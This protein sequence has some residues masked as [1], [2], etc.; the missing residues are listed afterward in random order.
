MPPVKKWGIRPTLLT[1][2]LRPGPKW[3]RLLVQFSGLAMQERLYL[4]EGD[5]V[6]MIVEADL[7][8][9]EDS[10]A[11]K[12][13]EADPEALREPDRG[14]NLKFPYTDFEIMKIGGNVAAVSNHN[15][16]EFAVLDID[17][18]PF[19]SSFVENTKHSSRV[20][21]NPHLFFKNGNRNYRH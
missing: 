17:P 19:R 12:N 14:S 5:L 1:K 15:H 4:L 9:I 13:V 21:I 6:D 20:N 8:L 3:P 7:E 18:H 16:L 10:F 2:I 11:P